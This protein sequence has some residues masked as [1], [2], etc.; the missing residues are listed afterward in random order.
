MPR[1]KLVE[2]NAGAAEGTALAPK[3]L[4]A[5]FEVMLTPWEPPNAGVEAATLVGGVGSNR[6]NAGVVT[7]EE[8]AVCFGPETGKCPGESGGETLDDDIPKTC[9]LSIRCVAV[10]M[11]PS[12]PSIIPG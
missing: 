5:K 10:G 3:R 2:P 8:P 4:D 9:T 11:T 12:P 1:E 6:P 7:V